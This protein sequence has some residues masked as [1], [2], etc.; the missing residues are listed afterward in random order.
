M[1]QCVQDA[2]TEKELKEK[3]VWDGHQRE[4]LN[5]TLDRNEIKQVDG[6]MYLGGMVIEDGRSTEYLTLTPLQQGTRGKQV[7]IIKIKKL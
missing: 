2:W 6:F 1:E 7:E 4:E 5:I 3:V